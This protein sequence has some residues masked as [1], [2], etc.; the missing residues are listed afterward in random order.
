M[1]VN[2]GLN[3]VRFV[4]PV[5]T[6]SRIRVHFEI[7]SVT[8]LRGCREVVI[9]SMVELENSQRP[10]CVIESVRRFYPSVEGDNE[11]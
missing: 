2:C 8:E 4:T 5:R 10:A 7:T 6:D 1:A 3:R 11:Q 9:N